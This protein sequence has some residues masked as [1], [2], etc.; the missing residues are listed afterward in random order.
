MNSDELIEKI[1][2]QNRTRAKR[3]YDKKKAIK[4][5]EKPDV[6]KIEVIDMV[7]EPDANTSI[8]RPS[9]E[10]IIDTLKARSIAPIYFNNFVQLI[11]ILEPYQIL[12]MFENPTEV[13]TNIEAVKQGS[14]NYSKI[15]IY[16]TILYLIDNF[17]TG[18]KDNKSLYN[19]IYEKYKIL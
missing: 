17:F 8:V 3:Y 13:I 15:Y 4:T 14:D 7:N 16:Q 11:R 10:Q 2:H 1:R 6:K 19:D 12:R 9:I 18:S 5:D